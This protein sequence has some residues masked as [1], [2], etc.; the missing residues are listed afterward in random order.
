MGYSRYNTKKISELI[1]KIGP[2]DV[3][4]KLDGAWDLSVFY[5]DR[6]ENKLTIEMCAS[7]SINGD[8]IVDPLMDIELILDSNGEIL[9]V[10][11]KFYQ[12][13]TPLAD[14]EIYSKDNTDCWNPELYEKPGQLDEKLS[15]WLDSIEMQGYLRAGKIEKI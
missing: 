4:I 14:I 10:H 5:V 2:S 1:K 3:A 8:M 13:Q 9:E 7:E 12:S 15:N 11:P 6:D